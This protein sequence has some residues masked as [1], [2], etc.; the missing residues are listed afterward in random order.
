MKIIISP[1]K[2][3]QFEDRYSTDVYPDESYKKIFKKLKVISKKN[4]GTAFGIKGNILDQTYYNIQNNDNLESNSAIRAYTGFVFKGLNLDL[5]SKEEWDYLNKNLIIISAYYGLLTPKTMIKP[6]RLDYKAKIGMDLYKYRK[7][8][9]EDTVVNLA[10][11]EFSK[12][13]TSPMITVGFK[14]Q[15]KGKFINKPTYSKQARGVL[16]DYLIK[17]QV[18][19]LDEIKCFSE[20]DYRFNSDLSDET[21]IVF[22]R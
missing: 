11:E 17:N 5:Y 9:F 14:E 15:V 8:S 1:S 22:T 2:S 16:L 7:F 12:T 13:V 3:M 21:N 6:Y 20:L 10:S 19:K 4:L 18:N